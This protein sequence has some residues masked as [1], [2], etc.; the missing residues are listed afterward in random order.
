MGILY[1]GKLLI[2]QIPIIEFPYYLPVLVAVC[3]FI[4]IICFLWKDVVNV[5]IWLSF[6]RGGKQMSI[7][8]RCCLMYGIML[9]LTGIILIMC[10]VILELI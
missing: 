8:K 10:A 7:Y 4:G 1:K 5:L 6:N 3:M 2:A 9:L